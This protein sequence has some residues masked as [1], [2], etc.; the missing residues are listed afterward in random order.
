MRARLP[1]A[2][3][4]LAACAEPKARLATAV[5]DTLPGGIVRVTSSGPTAWT[6]STGWTFHE[7]PAIQPAQGTPA[8]LI[9]PTSIAV[10]AQRRLY[11]ADTKPSVIK[12][13]DST[14]AFVRSIGHEGEGPGE[15]R[16]AYIAVRGNRLLVHDPMATRTSFFDTSGTFLRSFH[17]VGMY[18][19]DV[20]LDAAG[21]AVL[22]LIHMVSEAE[23]AAGPK[24]T[25]F[26]IRFD[27]LGA[28]RDTLSVPQLTEEHSW[29]VKR[30]AANIF[31]TTVPFA[32]RTIG[33]YGLDSGLVYGA[34]T[35][36]AIMR[37]EGGRDTT[38]IMRRAWTAPSIPDRVRADTVE[39]MIKQFTSDRLDAISLRNAFHLADVPTTGPSFSRLLVDDHRNTWA[40]QPS[41]HDSTQFDIFAPGGAWLGTITVPA[42]MWAYGPLLVQ[43]GVMYLATED[44]SGFPVIRRWKIEDGPGTRRGDRGA[45]T[46]QEGRE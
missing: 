27:S 25:F 22:P 9:E 8:E 29:V 3:M 12:V 26:R 21:R 34:T 46:G 44:K 43:G 17:S 28:V 14:G 15:F 31:A 42:P 32:A 41:R 23:Q 45:R 20:A 13:F 30:G 24:R 4:L 11:V 16:S 40:Q 2:L 7:L 1:L 19:G 35:D 38:F 39:G 18:F 33:A 5:I 6:D 37:A 36:F 10:D